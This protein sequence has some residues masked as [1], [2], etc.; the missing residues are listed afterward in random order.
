MLACNTN[1]PT[2]PRLS[3]TISGLITNTNKPTLPRLSIT[4]SG[5]I[6]NTDKPTLPRL[7]EYNDQWFDY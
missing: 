5:L 4:I 1:K 6:I 3:I 7:F 2:L